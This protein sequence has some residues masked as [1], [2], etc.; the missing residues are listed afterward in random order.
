[1]PMKHSSMGIR[2]NWKP[3]SNVRTAST[4]SGPS[5]T[6]GA[7]RHRRAARSMCRR[8]PSQHTRN[9]YNAKVLAEMFGAKPKEVQAFLGELLPP[10]RTLELH[11]RPLAAG[12]P[13]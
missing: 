6:A 13:Q 3:N 8:N 4:T 12:V 1:M 9:G 2:W 7:K 5:T 11:D 10:E